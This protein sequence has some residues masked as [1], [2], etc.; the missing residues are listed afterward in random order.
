[1]TRSM[2]VYQDLP[3]TTGDAVA[4]VV[5]LHGHGGTV[6]ELVPLCREIHPSLHIVTPQAMRPVNAPS[7]VYTIEDEGGYR[8]CFGEPT[9]DPEPATFGESLWSIEQFVYD[10][11]DRMAGAE[12]PIILLGREQGAL[13]ALTMAM[14]VP[15]WLAG[16]VA[17]GGYLPVIRGWSPPVETLAGLPILVVHEPQQE[18]AQTAVERTLVELQKRQGVV[19]ASVVADVQRNPSLAVEPIRGWLDGVVSR[20]SVKPPATMTP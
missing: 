12:R 20:F 17:I 6:D 16:V 15:E 8:W 1:M 7:R 14:I 18:G 10:V 3:P 5:A 19:T 13:V 4:T 2:L 11:K 9:D